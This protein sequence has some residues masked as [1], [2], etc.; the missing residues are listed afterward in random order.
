M[1]SVSIAVHTHDRGSLRH[2]LRN[3]NNKLT[4]ITVHQYTSLIERSSK[5]DS[6]LTERTPTGY[7]HSQCVHVS[8]EIHNI[9]AGEAYERD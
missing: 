2:Y 8:E 7:R 3:K 6:F 1:K 5:R 9:Y 4:R